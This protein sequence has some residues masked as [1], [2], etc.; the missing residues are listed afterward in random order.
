VRPTG[1]RPLTMILIAACVFVAIATDGGE[2]V[3][4]DLMNKLWF[5][6][7]PPQN[8]NFM[9]I[10][11]APPAT[12]WTPT[13]QIEKGEVWRLVTPIFIHYGPMHLI[14]NMYALYLFGSLIEI[15]RGT[16]RF[17]LLVLATAIFSNFC[18]IFIPY[19][20]HWAGPVDTLFGGMSG[21]DYALFGYIWIKSR[22]EPQ[23]NFFMPPNFVVM[24]LVWLVLCFTGWVGPI[25]NWAHAG[26]LVSGAAIAFASVAWRKLFRSSMQ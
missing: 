25:A 16:F 19:H 1:R 17:G 7:P 4:G 6:P 13:Q 18:Q 23:L 24:M 5:N 3:T 26:G 20:F 11:F 22:F 9:G 14:F 12:K 8:V 2:N 15:R 21:V 10:V